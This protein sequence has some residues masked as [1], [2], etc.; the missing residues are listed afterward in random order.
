MSRE[1]NK[2]YEAISKENMKYWISAVVAPILGL[3]ILALTQA[4]LWGTIGFCFYLLVL[5]QSIK[6]IRRNKKLKVKLLS[7]PNSVKLHEVLE[8]PVILGIPGLHW[9]A[10]ISR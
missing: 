3:F 2:V 6:G 5:V 7:A 1:A 9:F 10:S 8:G 4:S